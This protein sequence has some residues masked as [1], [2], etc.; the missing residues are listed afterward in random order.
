MAMDVGHYFVE[1][2][3]LFDCVDLCINEG[4]RTIILGKNSSGKSTLL[5]IL[6]GKLAPKEGKVHFAQSIKE[7]IGFFDQHIADNMIKLSMKQTHSHANLL[8]PLSLLTEQFP[9]KTEQELRGELASF[10]ISPKQATT[11][12]NFLSGGERWRLCLT[13]TM[14]RRPDV[15]IL[16]KIIKISSYLSAFFFCSI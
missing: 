11:S 7:S 14:L 5:Q 10:G 8:T 16:G 13:M 12:I 1:D 2:K 6:A 9:L 4:S 3:T 15:L